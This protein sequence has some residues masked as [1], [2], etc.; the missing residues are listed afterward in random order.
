VSEL[1]SNLFF[2]AR[3][4][5]TI[6]LIGVR[7]NGAVGIEVIAQDEGPGIDDV[8]AA[9]LDGFTTNGGLGGGLPGVER[10]MD[11]FEIESAPGT[12]TRVVARK[13]S[14]CE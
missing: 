6:T 8:E 11:E 7:R 4:G 5:R 1:A 9:M 14:P 10:L 2:H 13:W 12:G 3:G